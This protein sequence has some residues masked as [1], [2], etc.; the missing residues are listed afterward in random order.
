MDLKESNPW[1]ADK[2]A[3]EDQP[4][5]RAWQESRMRWDPHPEYEF[6]ECDC[7]YSLRGPRQVGKTT[8]VKLEIRRLLD[9]VPA[10]DVMYC[11]FDPGGTP[12]DVVRTVR[13]YIDRRG[14]DDGGRRFLFLDEISSVRGWQRGMKHLRDSDKLAKC[15]VLVTGSHA[16]D[17][18]RS[19]ELLPGRRGLP[20]DGGLDKTLSPMKF[21]E[22]VG[23]V[24]PILAR[25]CGAC[26]GP[27]GRLAEI[28]ELATGGIGGGLRELD[29]LREKL[30]EHLDNYLIAGG[31]PSSAE[32]FLRHGRVQG[33]IYRAYMDAITGDMNSAGRDPSHLAQIAAGIAE[34]ACSPVSWNALMKISG[35]ASHHTAAEHVRA[36]ADMFVLRVMHRYDM[37]RDGPKFVSPKKIH[38]RDPLFLHVMVSRDEPY[39]ASLKMLASPEARGALCEQV[40]AEHAARLAFDM[41]GRSDWFNHAKSVFY[42]KSGAGREVDV[43]FRDGKS[44]VPLD[45]K[46]QSRISRRDAHGLIDFAKAAG[47]RGGMLITRGD[48]SESGGVS[49][50]PISLFLALC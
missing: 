20:E 47:K 30:D 1:W 15:T 13:E 35:F 26:A 4:E 24:D 11:S 41:A 44:L 6:E 7:I 28:R 19:A 39:E 29:G 17:V 42:W 46:C 32:S 40:A 9:K 49:R 16:M 33:G 8:L 12:R 36:L 31:M 25:K 21:A 45:V 34:A 43:V 10:G 48:L 18:R 23:A 50:V 5:I 3:I 14:P 22:Y 38:F 37:S 2:D 27:G